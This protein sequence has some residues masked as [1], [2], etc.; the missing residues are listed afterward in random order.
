MMVEPGGPGR[1]VQE[2]RS[3]CAEDQALA[4][5]GEIGSPHR[6]VFSMSVWWTP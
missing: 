5:M 2:F 4:G 6:A 1:L 3:E